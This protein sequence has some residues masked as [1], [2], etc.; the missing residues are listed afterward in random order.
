M[1]HGRKES[2]VNRAE[3]FTKEMAIEKL[4][5]CSDD[6][7]WFI[8]RL[9]LA[10][11]DRYGDEVFDILKEVGTAW[12]Q[13]TAENVDRMLDVRGL[14]RNDPRNFRTCLR[15]FLG[16][17]EVAQHGNERVT[18]KEDGKIRVEYELQVCPYVKVWNEMGIPKGI[19]EKLCLGI[20]NQGDKTATAYHGI[21]Y[22][23]DLGLPKGTGPCKMVLDKVR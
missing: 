12:G 20:G 5:R 19:Q 18:D 7:V 3:E 21:E 13:R 2:T 4:N 23:S 10:F 1:G 8:T 14:D 15:D 16:F 22:T 11:R 17:L 6:K 9:V